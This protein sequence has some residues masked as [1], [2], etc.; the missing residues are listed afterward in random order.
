MIWHIRIILIIN[1][2]RKSALNHPVH[3]TNTITTKD[4]QND[5]AKS[6]QILLS[7]IYRRKKSKRLLKFHSSYAH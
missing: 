2:L 3:V 6:M 5:L 4:Y 1:T 7:L